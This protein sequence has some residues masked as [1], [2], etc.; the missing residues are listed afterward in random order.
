ME[1]EEESW[2]DQDDDEEQN[3]GDEVMPSVKSPEENFKSYN[4]FTKKNDVVTSS[5]SNKVCAE[6]KEAHT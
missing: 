3:G 2:F 1:E 4:S 6:E 5:T